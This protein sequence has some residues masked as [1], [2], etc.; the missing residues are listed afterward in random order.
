M[1]TL[2]STTTSES[3]RLAARG[4]GA[5]NPRNV[6]HQINISNGLYAA[7]CIGNTSH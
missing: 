1:H 2:E 4:N 6:G 3:G 5:A 7:T